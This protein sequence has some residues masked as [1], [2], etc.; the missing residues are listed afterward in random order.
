MAN[1]PRSVRAICPFYQRIR[2]LETHRAEIT[3]EGAVPGMENVVSFRSTKLMEDWMAQYC[4]T[5]AYDQC[6]H[7]KLI[8][9]KYLRGDEE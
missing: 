4:S 3:C 6:P 2:R 1:E 7:A 5:Y 9:E 8:S